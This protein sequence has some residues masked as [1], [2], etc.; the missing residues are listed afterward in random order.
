[1]RDANPHHFDFAIRAVF[2][3]FVA[4]RRRAGLPAAALHAAAEHARLHGHPGYR[5]SLQAHCFLAVMEYAEDRELRCEMYLARHAVGTDDDPATDT[6]PIIEEMLALRGQRAALL[7]FGSFADFATA[8]RMMKDGQSAMRF[9]QALRDRI[10]PTLDRETGEL[11]GFAST[12]GH[13]APEAWDVAFLA[14]RQRRARVGFDPEALRDYF[15]RE[16]VLDGIFEVLRRLWG[17]RVVPAPSAPTWH[18]EVL[19][20]DVHDEDGHFG[21]FYLDLYSR[22]SKREGAWMSPVLDRTSSAAPLERRLSIAIAATDLTP[23]APGQPAR[24]SHREVVRLF[25][26]IGHVCHHLLSRVPARTL[27]GTRVAWDFV[28]FPS[29]IFEC[30]AWQ[31]EVLEL[32]S[33][34]AQTGAPLPVELRDGLVRLRRYRAASGLARQLSYAAVDLDLHLHPASTPLDR[35]T[36]RER[37]HALFASFSPTPLPAAASPVSSF[38]HI[39]ASASGYEACFYAYVWAEVL[40][41]QAVARMREDGLLSGKAGD[42]LR[43]VLS[44]GNGRDPIELVRECLGGEPDLGPFLEWLGISASHE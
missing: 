31:P 22:E 26:E 20:F 27:S 17:L 43:R 12:L 1:M 3:L 29:L 10:R 35:H 5:L 30:L 24:F 40:A 11:V 7:G 39:F 37:A 44:S 9:V 28:E 8:E 25:H 21:T 18:A 6:R 13:P 4:A 23:P 36:I 2:W 38:S 33:G 41:T 42:R 32:V 16:R 14:E 34:H 19:A 15:P